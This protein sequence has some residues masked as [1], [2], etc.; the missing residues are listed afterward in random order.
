VAKELAAFTAEVIITG[1][2]SELFEN[3]YSPFTANEGPL[4]GSTLL[5]LKSKSHVRNAQGKMSAE[6]FFDGIILSV[7]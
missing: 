7:K 5:Y 1:N 2:S 6:I 3:I 4:S